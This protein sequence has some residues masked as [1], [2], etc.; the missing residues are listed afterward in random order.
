MSIRPTSSSVD[1]R[2]TAQPDGAVFDLANSRVVLQTG[3]GGV[4]ARIE[5]GDDVSYAGPLDSPT[6]TAIRRVSRE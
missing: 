2:P 5:A 3:P 6:I 1:G 4:F